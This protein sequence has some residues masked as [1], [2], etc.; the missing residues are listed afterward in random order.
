MGKY[1]VKKVFKQVKSLPSGFGFYPKGTEVRFSPMTTGEIE[2][3]NESDLSSLMV[4]KSALE[5]IQ[6]T[7]IQPTDLTFSDFVFISLQ[8]RLYSQTEIRCTLNT[9]CP[10]CGTRIVQD[11]DFNELEFDE[12]KDN[13]LQTCTLGGYKVVVGPLTIGNM[14]SMLESERGVNTVDTLAH[15]IKKIYLPGSEVAEVE[16]DELFPL[17]QEIIANTW[18]EEREVMNY[19]DSLQSHGLLPRKITCKNQACKYEWEEDLGTPDALIFPSSK[20][21]QSIRDKVHA[22]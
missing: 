17:A 16:V 1:E 11:F 9:T 2:T 7:K 14:I 3:L 12:P 20:P 19:I 15:C 22:C 6:T 18:G 13:R 8:R 21:E 5:G 10:N 4:F